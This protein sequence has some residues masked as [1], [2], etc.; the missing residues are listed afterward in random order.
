MHYY[1]FGLNSQACGLAAASCSDSEQSLRVLVLPKF[2][3]LDRYNCKSPCGTIS[4]KFLSISIITSE[5]SFCA[6]DAKKWYEF[7]NLLH[8]LSDSC[9]SPASQRNNKTVVSLIKVT[10]KKKNAAKFT[11]DDSEPR[12]Y[13]LVVQNN[14][15]YLCDDSNGDPFDLAWR[16]LLALWKYVQDILLRYLRY[17]HQNLSATLVAESGL[18]FLIHRQFVA[19]VQSLIGHVRPG[20]S[21]VS[22]RTP[23]LRGRID[24]VDALVA[25]QSGQSRVKCTFDEFG[26][27]T[28]LMRVIVTALDLVSQAQVTL[29]ASFNRDIRH[30]ASRLRG[31]L[32][33]IPSLPRPHALQTGRS[34][35]PRLSR[36]DRTWKHSLELAVLVLDIQ[37]CS[38]APGSAKAPF[39]FAKKGDRNNFYFYISTAVLW[40]SVLYR[41]FS[42]GKI[43]RKRKKTPWDNSI[44]KLGYVKTP[45]ILNRHFIIDAKYKLDRGVKPDRSRVSAGDQYQIFTYSHLYCHQSDHTRNVML[46]YAHH[47][48]VEVSPSESSSIIYKRF[49][50]NKDLADVFLVIAKFRFPQPDDLQNGQT[51]GLYKKDIKK[52]FE[53]YREAILVKSSCSSAP[54]STSSPPA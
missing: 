49:K 4:R 51:I 18:E 41:V 5:G 42:N 14:E 53:K 38:P 29:G 26:P 35:I 27:Q 43:R 21:R 15:I 1:A 9:N 12:N 28:P 2:W 52:E 45:D 16:D 13:T 36:V 25:L 3:K 20:Y 11:F 39:S 30:T 24:M 47:E 44:D 31:R 19:N 6:I 23:Y 40:Q 48:N 32:N 37:S 17:P 7:S 50:G 34:L 10:S 22:K 33:E 46:A 8:D 54:A